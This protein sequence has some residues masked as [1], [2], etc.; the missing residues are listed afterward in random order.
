MTMVTT[1]DFG[2]MREA[3]VASQLRTSDVTDPA[4]VTAMATVERHRF[5]PAD[6]AA[7]AYTDRPVPLS[8]GRA[9]NPPLATGRLLAAAELM[10]SDT[11]LLIGAATGYSAAVLARI[12]ARVVAVES[13]A[14]LIEF[15]RQNLFGIANVELVEGPLDAGW[16]KD[17]PFSL[18]LIDG[19][20]EGVGAKLAQQVAP[21]GRVLTGIADRGVTRICR[22]VPSG[23]SVAL[24]PIADTEM[25][26][27][28]GFA[29]PKNF[30]FA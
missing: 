11:V 9:L 8:A 24:V 26:V 22:G 23:N 5:V 2:A 15:A 19:A 16:T 30:V 20:V 4:I 18:I 28:P 13:N 12:V 14:T 6:R 29:K 17:A 21:D 3:M 10:P 1:H 25:V 7:L 27:L